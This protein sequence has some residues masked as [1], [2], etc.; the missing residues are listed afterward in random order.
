LDRGQQGAIAHFVLNIERTEGKQRDAVKTEVGISPTMLQQ[1][2]LIRGPAAKDVEGS[3][4]GGECDERPASRLEPAG[5]SGV[6][7][8]TAFG[9]PAGEQ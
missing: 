2:A 5:L 8:P 9:F 7:D 1:Q 3:G 4:V 6:V